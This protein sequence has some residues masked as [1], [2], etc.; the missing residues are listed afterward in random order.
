MKI[1]S[2]DGEES[3]KVLALQEVVKILNQA[4]QKINENDCFSTAIMVGV[5]I[6]YLENLK[7]ELASQL[8]LE[9][10][11]REILKTDANF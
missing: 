7:G 3:S 6:S 2:T 11:L 1:D 8:S 9:K 10:K 5:A 4:T